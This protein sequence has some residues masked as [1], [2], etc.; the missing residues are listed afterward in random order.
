M[1]VKACKTDDASVATSLWDL[2][3]LLVLPWLL[4]VVLALLRQKLLTR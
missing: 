1:A 2:C 4:Y 3:I